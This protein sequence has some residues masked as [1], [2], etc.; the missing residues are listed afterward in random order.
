MRK[1]I[2]IKWLGFSPGTEIPYKEDFLYKNLVQRYNI[3]ISD[4]PDFLICALTNFEDLNYNCVKIIRTIENVIPDFNRYDYVMGFDYLTLGDRYLRFPLFAAY[5]SYELLK[6]R[7]SRMPSDEDLIN[8]KFC[9]F[10]VSNGEGAD[11]IRDEFFRRLCKYKKVDSGG[12]HLNNIAGAVADK[13]EFC[14]GYKFNIAI[15][16]SVSPGYTTEKVMQPLAAYSVPIYHGDPLVTND[17]T[18][19]CMV[20]IHDAQDIDRAIEEIISLDND[21]ATYLAKVKAACLVKP[22]DYYNNQLSDFLDNIFR[23]SPEDARRTVDYG[24]QIHLRQKLRKLYKV[25]WLA[26]C[27]IRK[28]IRL[29]KGIAGKVF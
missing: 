9:S 3:E 22:W 29:I 6:N 24:Y 8:R 10:V 21:D 20:R 1:T 2:K 28:P 7:A 16:N 15:E 4:D 19:D 17:F 23:Q 18:S 14:R 26:S 27:V 13:L 12:R 11:P 25:G 5:K